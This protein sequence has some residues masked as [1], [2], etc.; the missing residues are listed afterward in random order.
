[1]STTYEV[2]LTIT[3]GRSGRARSKAALMLAY[4]ITAPDTL[5]AMAGDGLTE[6]LAAE[7]FALNHAPE[8]AEVIEP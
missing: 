8:V 2:R 3:D 7:G 6:R 1:M 5:A 4:I